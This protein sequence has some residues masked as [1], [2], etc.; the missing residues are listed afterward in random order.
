VVTLAARCFSALKKRVSA[1]SALLTG[2]RM[3][4]TRSELKQRAIIHRFSYIHVH[5]VRAHIH[6]VDTLHTS[7]H[8]CRYMRIHTCIHTIIIQCFELL[9]EDISHRKET[10]RAT[11]SRVYLFCLSLPRDIAWRRESLHRVEALQTML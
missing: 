7:I 9:L 11:R 8:V 2:T 5:H 1:S 6:Y 4:P 10:N 3:S